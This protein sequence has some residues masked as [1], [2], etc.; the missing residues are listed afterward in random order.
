MDFGLWILDFGFP[1]STW[2]AFR[3]WNQEQSKIQNPK[4]ITLRLMSALHQLFQS[5]LEGSIGAVSGLRDLFPVIVAATEAML[6]GVRSGRTIFTAGNGGS[7]AQALHLS[8]ELIGRYRGNRPAHAAVCLNADPT[9]LTCI[10]NDFGFDE[11]FARQCEAL[12]ERGDVL[13]V[14]STSGKSANIIAA[15]N[16]ARQRGATTIGL[17]GGDG[18]SCAPLCDHAIVVPAADSA[19]VQEA[20]QVVI[21]L[22]CEAAETR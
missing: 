19:H 3:C 15:L 4:F 5:R 12:L 21:H 2:R 13:I 8:E 10:A 7:A 6:N 14:L 16:V 20:H 9:A 22:L 18:G 11:V 1:A 17:L